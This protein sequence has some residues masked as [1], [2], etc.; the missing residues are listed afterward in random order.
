VNA[1]CVGGGLRVTPATE[2]LTA[3]VQGISR[4][5]G[6][7]VAELL[8]RKLVRVGA[9]CSMCIHTCTDACMS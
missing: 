9:C 3:F 2:Q 4:L 6:L 1:L 8:Q 5:D 7:K